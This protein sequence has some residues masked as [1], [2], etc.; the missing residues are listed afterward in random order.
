MA[1]RG[2]VEPEVGP[3]LMCL[4]QQCRYAGNLRLVFCPVC[5]GQL[6]RPPG[7]YEKLLSRITRLFRLRYDTAPEFVIG[8]E[9]T[10]MMQ[11]AD[12][13]LTR[14]DVPLIDPNF[15]EDPDGG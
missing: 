13:V 6:M 11:A 14:D 15:P 9:K 1:R 10:L 8:R 5:N 7:P 4:N 12:E 2:E 3:F